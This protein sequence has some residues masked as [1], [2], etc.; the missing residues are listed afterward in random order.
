MSETIVPTGE[1][2]TVPTVKNKIPAKYLKSKGDNPPYKVNFRRKDVSDKSI[3]T[4]HVGQ[5][6]RKNGYSFHDVARNG[7]RLATVSFPTIEAANKTIDDDVLKQF[8]EIFI[9]NSFVFVFGYISNVDDSVELDGEFGLIN[10]LKKSNATISEVKPIFYT[11]R[12]DG[13]K[14]RS[15]K[16]SITFR[17]KLL[18][19]YI[20]AFGVNLQVSPFIN[21]V[22]LCAACARFGHDAAACRQISE[23]KLCFKKTC[24]NPNECGT[25]TCKLCKSVDHKTGDKL[26][27]KFQE[28]SRI[29]K[30]MAVNNIGF[31]QARSQVVTHKNYF[32]ELENLNDFP[33]ISSTNSYA[34]VMKTTPKNFHFSPLKHSHT[35]QHQQKTSNVSPIERGARAEQREILKRKAGDFDNPLHGPSY[36]IDLS[37]LQKDISG[38]NRQEKESVMQSITGYMH[39][40]IK[41]LIDSRPVS[42]NITA[43]VSSSYDV[44]KL[45]INE[46]SQAAAME[47]EQ[48]ES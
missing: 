5:M 23:C 22:K 27:P 13:Q 40:I 34:N 6:L 28:Q 17:A 31:N 1:D 18:P 33:E 24:D 21:R 15:H 3:S 14:K 41:K 10:E 44:K 26:C 32:A 20:S 30:C 16:V 38:L 35:R 37:H 19:K 12:K 25:N 39:K 9:P 7:R 42:T 47:D 46:N 8:Y 43:S 48:M 36:G 11:D 4:V 29:Y 2:P 45:K